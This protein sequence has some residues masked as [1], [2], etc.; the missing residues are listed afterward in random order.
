LR[1]W[2][3]GSDTASVLARR[4]V[5]GLV[6]RVEVETHANEITTALGRPRLDAADDVAS[7]QPKP[8]P[9]QFIAIDPGPGLLLYSD[10]ARYR[11]GDGLHL[12]VRV[13]AD[14]HL[15]I[16]SVD[17]RGR[18][19]VLFPS[20]FETN[21]LLTA[22]TELKLPG[23]GAPYTLRL[24]ETGRETV[25]ALCNEAGPLTD[26]IRHDFERQ[27]FTDLGTYATFVS[28]NALTDQGQAQGAAPPGPANR[29]HRRNPVDAVP[30]GP[31]RPVQISRTAISIIVE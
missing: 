9:S 10:K 5:Q 15:T 7:E 30:E 27:R 22:G 1:R 14:C 13:L 11:K 6:A 25:V 2:G 3:G 12:T 16:I 21:G 20:D 8:A 23:P 17:T 18:G 19:T 26:N 28:R 24:N 31:A 4:L 29:T